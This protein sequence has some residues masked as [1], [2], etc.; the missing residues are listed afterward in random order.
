MR[1]FTLLMVLMMFIGLGV[2]QAQ[3][4]IT[5]KV[6]SSEDGSGIP[7]ATILVKGTTVGVITD[8]DGKYSLTVPAGKEVITVSFVGM[9]SVEV[10]LGTT[11]VI[12][13]EL[14]PDV[15]ALEGVVVTALGVTR[16]K[17]ALGYSV[18]DLKG[19][20]L[21]SDGSANVI[22]QL[23]GR[24][25]GVQVTSSSGNMGGSSRVVIRGINSISGNN[26]PLYI[27]DGTI[28]DNSDFNTTD[29]ARGAGGYDYG[30][31]AQDINPDDIA[32]ISV[33][34]GANAAA[35]YGSRAANGVILITTKKG[36]KQK[37]KQDEIQ[38]KQE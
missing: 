28:I 23:S 38:F 6:T 30:N 31:M 35:L 24:V 34:K 8:L 5:G 22:N 10:T 19:D 3:K 36:E 16:E 32:S 29:A 20:Q 18:Q 1:K 4:V 27:V 11:N 2:T 33:L 9:K 25:A 14:Q 15:K 13:V 26:Q 7:G 17:K 21:Q 37:G 12:N